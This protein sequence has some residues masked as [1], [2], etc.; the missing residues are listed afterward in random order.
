M[1]GHGELKMVKEEMETSQVEALKS[2]SPEQ[3]N[4]EKSGQTW[5]ESIDE[6]RE[7][8]VCFSSNYLTVT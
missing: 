1:R 2:S 4:G 3:T 6:V 5:T 7:C 8:L